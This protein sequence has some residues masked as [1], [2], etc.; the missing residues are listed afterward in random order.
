MPENKDTDWLWDDFVAKNNDE[1]VGTYG[2]F[3]HRVVTFTEKNFGKIP[4]LGTLD[5]LDKEALEKIKETSK[6][7]SD[8]LDKFEF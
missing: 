3:V 1:L 4:K 2:N 8:S 5:K 7:I 6:E